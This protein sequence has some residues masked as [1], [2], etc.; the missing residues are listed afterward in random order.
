M[1]KVS[2][3]ATAPVQARWLEPGHE[4]DLELFIGSPEI[5]KFAAVFNQGEE[6]RTHVEFGDLRVHPDHREDGLATRLVGA[7]AYLAVG[8]EAQTFSGS[9]DSQ[10]SLKILSHI[11]GDDSITFSD[12][13]PRTMERVGLPIDLQ[14]AIEI[15][16]R[17]EKSESDPEHREQNLIVHANLA[18]IDPA[19]LEIPVE[20]NDPILSAA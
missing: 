7:L 15:L 9:I 17:A 8:R 16:E 10:Y 2:A 18:S 5:A 1:N 12:I 11:L 20:L 13:D 4:H 6:G 3:Y 14:Q 19:S